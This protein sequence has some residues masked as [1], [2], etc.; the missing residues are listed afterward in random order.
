MFVLHAIQVPP[1]SSIDQRFFWWR[2]RY[3]LYAAY[4]LLQV[5]WYTTE[6]G[7]L[8]LGI[9][10]HFYHIITE[11]SESQ[12]RKSDIDSSSLVISAN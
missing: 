4:A 3:N 7:V 5:F 2:F 1:P 12:K 9:E 10:I 8:A 6:H 11:K